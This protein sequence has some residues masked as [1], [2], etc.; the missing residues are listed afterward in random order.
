[1]CIDEVP[2]HCNVILIRP[3]KKRLEAEIDL[4]LVSNGSDEC[5]RCPS[6]GEDVV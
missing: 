5:E 4:A 2:A 3:H 1:M 6:C